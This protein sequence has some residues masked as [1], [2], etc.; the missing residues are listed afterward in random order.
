MGR[1]GGKESLDRLH[2]GTAVQPWEAVLRRQDVPTRAA[3][4]ELKRSVLFHGLDAGVL[5]PLA[6]LALSHT[7]GRGELDLN[8]DGEVN[9]IS[10]LT[11][12]GAL[13]IRCNRPVVLLRMT[14]VVQ[15]DKPSNKRWQ[16][17]VR[18]LKCEY[19]GVAADQE[20][21]CF[22]LLPSMTYLRAGEY[23][24]IAVIQVGEF[25]GRGRLET[26]DDRTFFMGSTP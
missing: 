3:L 21:N 5:L 1:A 18:P 10:Y 7:Y 17:I 13:H 25:R 8:P 16:R 2:V 14:V 26:F 19:V 12:Y 9:G 4:R 24:V 22:Q 6:H 23:R 11:E 15:F 20:R